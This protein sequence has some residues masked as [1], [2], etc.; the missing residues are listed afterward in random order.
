MAGSRLPLWVIVG[1]IHLHAGSDA[2]VAEDLARLVRDVTAESSDACVVMNG[3]VF[4]LD[5]VRGEPRGGVGAD[6]AAARLARILETHA[7]VVDCLAAHASKGGTVVFVAG[8]HDAELLLAPVRDVL[9][10]AL[11]SSDRVHV[12]DRWVVGDR[13]VE[14]GH[15][16]DPDS[17]F[18][19]DPATALS[20]TRLSAF[21]LASLI[22]RALLSHIPRFELAGHNHSPP[23]TVLLRVLRDYGLGAIPMIL[24]FPIAGTQIVGCAALASLRGDAPRASDASMGSPWRVARRLYL[25]RYAGAAIGLLA[26]LA[27]AFGLAPPWLGWPVGLVVVALAIPPSRRKQFAHRD[28]RMCASLAVQHAA[29]G[30][31]IVVLGHTH[32]AFIDELEG[33]ALHANHGAFSSCQGQ[34]RTCERSSLRISPEGCVS[35]HSMY[36][37]APATVSDPHRPRMR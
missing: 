34:P 11:G 2:C 20:K 25:D 15:Q 28:V 17:A 33:G 5:R 12:V 26:L 29:H 24:R 31:R 8:N 35:L 9:L 1:D 13:V 21:P 23:L 37:E 36:P 7:A 22:T 3:D 18:Y 16:A 19:P 6:R 4:D 32:R 10:R 27:L 14:H 30:A